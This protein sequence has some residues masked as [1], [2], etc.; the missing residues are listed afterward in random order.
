VPVA[1][2]SRTFMS[3]PPFILCMTR[4]LVS[5]AFGDLLA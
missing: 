3:V 1:P 4:Y 2:A 5:S